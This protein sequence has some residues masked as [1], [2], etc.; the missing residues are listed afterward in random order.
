M[1]GNVT[2]HPVLVG[3]AGPLNGEQWVIENTLTIGREPACDIVIT[4]RQISRY[5]ARLHVNTM[6]VLLEDLAS[7]NGTFL[8]EKRVVEPQYVQ[9]GDM[10]TVAL[11][12][13]FVFLGSDTTMPMTYESPIVTPVLSGINLDYKSRRVWIAGNEV[14]PP[15]SLY[16]FRMLH[17]LYESAGEV[18]SRDELFEK[19]WG[20]DAV[21]GISDQALDALTRRVR[22]RIGMYDPD[23]EYIVTV[24]GSGLR[25]E[26]IRK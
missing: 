19:I 25:L 16:Q 14:I 22:D 15:L 24:R 23:T 26:N 21:E 2:G 18:V 11:V 20:H 9:D 3:Q 4:D 6:G 5:H 12:Q 17:A 13:H 10:I 8:N 1:E 7:K